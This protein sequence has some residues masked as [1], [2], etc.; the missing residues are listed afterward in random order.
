MQKEIKFKGMMKGINSFLLQTKTTTQKNRKTKEA[1]Y[2][3]VVG[4]E[5]SLYKNI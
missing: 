2:Y 4:S 5:L 3:Q 1:N